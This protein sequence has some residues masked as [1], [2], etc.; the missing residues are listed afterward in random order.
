[1]NE[2]KRENLRCWFEARLMDSGRNLFHKQDRNHE[3]QNVGWN[4]QRSKEEQRNLH[5]MSSA[6]SWRLGAVQPDGVAVQS[7]ARYALEVH[8]S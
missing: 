1:M 7:L 8:E 4:K 6:A 2:S 3:S 5:Q